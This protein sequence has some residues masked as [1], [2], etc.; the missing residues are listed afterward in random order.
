MTLY[1]RTTDARDAPR[2]FFFPRGFSLRIDWCYETESVEEIKTDRREIML[3]ILMKTG[4]S[5]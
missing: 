5:K 2:R 3:P 4:E 1:R